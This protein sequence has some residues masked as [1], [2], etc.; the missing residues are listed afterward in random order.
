MIGIQSWIG[1]HDSFQQLCFAARTAK[2]RK[3][4]GIPRNVRSTVGA[5]L[6]DRH[7]SEP[8]VCI[9]FH[10]FKNNDPK[11]AKML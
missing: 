1:H 8:L 10:F 11:I 4:T 6:T 9:S 5:P 3:R 7:T 2:L